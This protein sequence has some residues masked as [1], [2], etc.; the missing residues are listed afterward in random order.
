M[1]KKLFSLIHSGDVHIAPKTKIIPAE[2]LA[3]LQTADEI[4]ETVKKDTE[5]YKK[6]VV[7]EIEK[8]KELAQKEGY[9]AG[10][11][12]WVEKV[13]KLEQEIKI[14][15]KDMEKQVLPVAIKAAKK[16]V[17]KELEVSQSAIIDIVS[18]NL[19]AVS[20]HK[21][22]TIYV[23]RQDLQT[24]E[25]QRPQLKQIFEVLEVLSI[26]ERADI[27]PG[28]CIIETEGGI[29]NAQIDNRWK[30]LENAFEK[31]MKGGG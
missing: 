31:M 13:E 28:G 29:I 21:Q 11:K 9:E 5:N 3:E 25:A 12:F 24:L 30:I 14:V 27:M 7:G 10:F 20:Q 8:L 18:N 19:K 15:R 1:K 6:E 22:I 26:R 2:D 4:I 16:I 17:S 23:N